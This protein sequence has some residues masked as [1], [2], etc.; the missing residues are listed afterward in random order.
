MTRTRNERLAALLTEAGWSRAQAASA[1]NNIVRQTNDRSCTVIGRSHISMWVGGTRP[2]GRAP[3]ILCRA[4]S[5]Q[6]KREI[7]P[8]DL[9]FEVP[10]APPRGHAQW[11]VD[12]LV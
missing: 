4:L 7:T 3:I 8:N 10:N 5:R 9:G 6:L 11:S 1:Y 12:P 2:T